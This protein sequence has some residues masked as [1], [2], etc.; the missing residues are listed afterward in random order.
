MVDLNE[1]RRKLELAR[2]GSLAPQLRWEERS[3]QREPS[4]TVLPPAPRRRRSRRVQVCWALDVGAS[5]GVIL[6]TVTFALQV[7][8]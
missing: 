2:E 1:F 6:M 7:L 5:L 8:V 4:L 3:A